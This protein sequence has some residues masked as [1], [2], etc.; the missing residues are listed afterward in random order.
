[1]HT[2]DRLGLDL[3]ASRLRHGVSGSPR[4]Q[5]VHHCAR[6]ESV[7]GNSPVRILLLEDGELKRVTFTSR[8]GGRCASGRSYHWTTV[9]RCGRTH[10]SAVLELVRRE[11]ARRDGT[12]HAVTRMLQRCCS[13]SPSLRRQF[14]GQRLSQMLRQTAVGQTSDLQASGRSRS[15]V[16][17]L[18][19]TVTALA[20]RID[21]FRI[22][23]IGSRRVE[24]HDR[25]FTSP[26][27]NSRE[28]W[29]VIGGWRKG[30][31]YETMSDTRQHCRSHLLHPARIA[32]VPG[33]GKAHA[34]PS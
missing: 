25:C 29:P 9:W 32:L 8:C 16:S 1:M 12:L 23:K 15:S 6:S 5:A 24:E 18:A 26:P 34:H 17:R 21:R 2:S 20:R 14:P 4:R 11:P 10:S 27:R 7:R 28:E 19:K 13:A 31:G 22:M 30:Q 33:E 3:E